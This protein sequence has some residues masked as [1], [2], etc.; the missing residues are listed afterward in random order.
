[1]ESSTALIILMAAVFLTAGVIATSAVS[2]NLWT[3]TPRPV[4]ESVLLV[5]GDLLVDV[6]NPSNKV[7][8]CQVYAGD[9]MLSGPEEILPGKIAMYTG[10]AT[11]RY[12]RVDCGEGKDVRLAY[13]VYG[14]G[15]ATVRTTTST[16]TTV[17]YSTST[18]YS[19]TSTETSTQTSSSSSTS[20]TT[21]SSKAEPL[22]IVR[23]A[24]EVR[25]V[26][27]AGERSLTANFEAVV[28]G[29]LKPYTFMIFF[30]DGSSA[31]STQNGAAFTASRV[32]DS[33][34][35]YIASVSVT[36]SIGQTATSYLVV[37][38]G[39][40]NQQT[41]TTTSSSQTSSSSTSTTSSQ[42]STS[43]TTTTTTSSRTTTTSTST[44]TT[45]TRTR[46]MPPDYEPRCPFVREECRLI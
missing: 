23:F 18:S 5:G 20:S 7:L 13:Q 2:P 15:S 40:I 25:G 4:I 22:R 17:D 35:P 16:Q 26:G 36:D 42:T 46:R 28:H 21:T 30:G 6:R 32:Y 1:V 14:E 39:C 33:E 24:C 45:S 3:P 43:T 31:S 44:T 10:P 29:G 27:R 41:T 9:R 37:P 11:S 38:S 12:V 34:G 19:F 8:R